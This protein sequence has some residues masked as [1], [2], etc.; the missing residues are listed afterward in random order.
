VLL[1][2]EQMLAL[3]IGFL[4]APPE[5]SLERLR[6]AVAAAAERSTGEMGVALEHMESGV[7]VDVRGDVAYPM[8]STFKLPLLATLFH[9]IDQGNI[10]LEE[11]VTLEKGDLN[12]GSGRLDDF[13]A[14]GIS[15]S[16]DNLAVLMMRVSDNSAADALLAR[17]GLESVRERL[18]MLGIE[19][20]SVDRTAERLI[21]DSLGMAPERTEGMDRREILDFLNAYEPAPGELEAAA[22]AFESDPRDTA[23]PLAMNDLLR[24]IYSGRA[25]GDSS[26]RR[27]RE[28]L[29]ACETGRSRLPGL[30]PAGAATAHKTGT[31][32]GAVADVG[33]LVLPEGRGHVLISALTRGV[34]DRDRAERAIAEIA[35]YAY[36]YFQ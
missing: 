5:P 20:I 2:Q 32:G 3:A 11:R 1:Y 28:I 8:A 23:T 22:S 12:L 18:R 30:L 21:L 35:R 31:L 16:I 10:R 24:A 26:T 27:V 14:P 19:G 13:V 29:L 4:L 15:L 17:V 7:R 6:A 33:V 9:Q 25:A 34:Q 36:D